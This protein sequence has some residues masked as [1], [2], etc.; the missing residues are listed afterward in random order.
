[1]TRSPLH[2]FLD[3]PSFTSQREL[4]GFDD[5]R[6]IWEVFRMDF[7]GVDKSASVGVNIIRSPVLGGGRP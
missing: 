1:M 7:F 2:L 5:K 4:N 6:D 3:C